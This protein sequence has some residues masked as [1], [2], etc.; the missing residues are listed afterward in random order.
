MKKMKTIS[1]VIPTFNSELT[2]R[3]CLE[4]IIKQKV[5]TAYGIQLETEQILVGF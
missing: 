5:R 3:R 4:S 1:V 2:L